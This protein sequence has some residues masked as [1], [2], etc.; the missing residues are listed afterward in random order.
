MYIWYVNR[1]MPSR[2]IRDTNFKVRAIEEKQ[3][4]SGL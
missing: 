1:Q 2:I 3:W 4:K